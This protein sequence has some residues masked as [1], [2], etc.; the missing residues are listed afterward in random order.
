MAASAALA[1]S[2]W[3][4]RRLGDLKW[5]GV[6][7]GAAVLLLAIPPTQSTIAGTVVIYVAATAA[8]LATS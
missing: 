6:C 7:G 5:A 3:R 1:V 4:L 2:A 8:F